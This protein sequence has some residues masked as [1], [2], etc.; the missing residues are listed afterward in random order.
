M[1]EF[2]VASSVPSLQYQIAV[3][4]HA[5]AKA[6]SMGL[7]LLLGE[8]FDPDDPAWD[9]KIKMLPQ[10]RESVETLVL[11]PSHGVFEASD[12]LTRKHDWVQ[13]QEEQTEPLHR[14]LYEPQG[15]R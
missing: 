15:T 10:L 11:L 9:E 1:T 6:D 12:S 2:E 13:M 3:L 14:W 4:Q 5:M 8:S 7:P